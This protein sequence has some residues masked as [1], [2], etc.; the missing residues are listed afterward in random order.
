MSVMWRAFVYTFFFFNDTA[1]T[2]IYT[3]SLHDALPIWPWYI[4]HTG[5]LFN[6]RPSTQ[7]CLIKDTT[8]QSED[9]NFGVAWDWFTTQDFVILPFAID[10]LSCGQANQ[11]FHE[12]HSEI[13]HKIVTI[14]LS[15]TFSCFGQ[16][17]CCWKLKLIS[18][19]SC[20]FWM[21]SLHNPYCMSHD[22]NPLYVDLN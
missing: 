1:T 15:V 12:I 19:G 14:S 5:C 20:G 17:S 3:L 22:I 6:K 2:E 4:C 11:S 16:N 9:V 10:S 7:S 21:L 8:Q 13:K 18:G